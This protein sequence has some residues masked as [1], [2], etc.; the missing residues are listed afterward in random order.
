MTDTISRAPRGALALAALAAE[1]RR[2]QAPPDR[3]GARAPSD[4]PDCAPAGPPPAAAS[5]SASPAPSTG[6]AGDPFGGQLAREEVRGGRS[7]YAA[8]LRA[9]RG[10]M[11]F[12]MLLSAGVAVLMLTGPIYMV[13][14]YDRVLA[15]GS[16]ST[17]TALFALAM[18]LYGFLGLY[19]YIRGR[20]LTRAAYRLDA[21]LAEPAFRA[22]LRAASG[23]GDAREDA[24]RRRR[25]GSAPPAPSDPVADVETVRGFVSGPAMAG[26][27]DLPFVPLFLGVTFLVHPAVGLVTLAGM[28]LAGI[29]ALVNRRATRRVLAEGAGMQAATA[30]FSEAL[31]GDAAGLR[32]M[33]MEDHVVRRRMEMHAAAAATLQQGGERGEGYA[34]ASRTLRMMLQSILLT[35]GAVLAI[36]GEISAGMIIAISIVAGRALAPL[37]QAI[38]QWPMIE[39]A[40][41]AHRGLLGADLRRPAPA[42]T[43][44]PEMTGHLTLTGVTVEARARGRA[45]V[46]DG[47]ALDL[48]PGDA[49]GVIGHSASGKST[50]ARVL[51]GALIP[52][53][54]EA[55]IDGAEHAQWDP[56]V[57]SR[58]LGYLPQ[59]VDL[60][61]GTIAENIARF[62]PAR[63]DAEIVAA[64]RLAGVHEMILA[65]P[66]GYRTRIDGAAP[67]SGGQVQRVGLARAVIGLPRLVVLD[68][69]N[70]HLDAPGDAALTRVVRA[71]RASGAAVVV[72]THRPAGLEAVN[73][74]LV[75]EGG[76]VAREGPKSMLMGAVGSGPGE[77]GQ[78]EEAPAAGPRRRGVRDIAAASR[79]ARA[80]LQTSGA[81]PAARAAVSAVPDRPDE[82]ALRAPD[83]LAAATA[84][85]AAGTLRLAPEVVAPARSGAAREGRAARPGDRRGGGV[86]SARAAAPGRRLAVR[87]LVLAAVLPSVGLA[88]LVGGW[89]A[90]APIDGAVVAS[91]AIDLRGQAKSVQS[92]D[93]GTVAEILVREGQV[94]AG[95]APLL[96]LDTTQ[97]EVEA[98]ILRGRLSEAALRERR[99]EAERVGAGTLAF[100]PLPPE[101]AGR[102]LAVEAAGQRAI[103]EARAAVRR[104][105]DEQLAER[106]A[107]VDAQIEGA[108]GQIAAVERQIALAAEEEDRARRLSEQ[109]LARAER[110]RAA[111]DRTADLG[112]RLAAL[113]SE[114]AR[115]AIALQDARL[116]LVQA[117]RTF[118]EGVVTELR[119]A[120]AETGELRLRLAEIGTRIARAEIP[121]PVSGMVHEMTVATVGGT[122]APGEVLMEVV[123]TGGRMDVAVKID[124]AQIDEIR[125]GQPVRVM[126]SG[127]GA[128][129]AP[130]IEGRV[131][132]ISP[133]AVEDRA[134]GR[135]FYRVGI[136]LPEA[137]VA[138]LEASG[139]GPLVPGMPV[140][141]FLT[142]GARTVLSYLARPI[143]DQFRRAFR[144]S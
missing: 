9:G 72:M 134:D 106:A 139:S 93:G 28:V 19:S 35:V 140:E 97:L 4:V 47:V 75:L 36:R 52:D 34:S 133:R 65:L 32:A 102:D 138:A 115:A 10:T 15:S 66:S 77:A 124:P 64:A 43:A 141:A 70:A 7:L 16:M 136:E 83:A 12:A 116:A 21:A 99:L 62:D 24:A 85:A 135:A 13:Q 6:A 1:P 37:D 117:E 107:Q 17:L 119:D 67:L 128:A 2:R 88:A 81:A 51:V 86:L 33:G 92:L 144:E 14:V 58:A 118:R 20:V 55:R 60:L 25:D 100:A 123:P 90:L 78:G 26:L 96:R 73:R 63:T 101:I 143:A 104:G 127:L 122:I 61:P 113:R 114:A 98:D 137:E 59:R 121:A 103:F 87:P 82:G 18:V 11:A 109:G 105:E 142:T 31:R 45:P 89:M 39:R 54:G 29:V 94:V 79:A 69:P 74:L 22:A 111:Q 53:R 125:I 91:G 48:A 120:A 49:L 84:E 3:A 40:L 57:L 110:L 46:L 42:P 38:G 5:A 30:R 130:E 50:L 8:A 56:A 126:L 27:M 44:L 80:R 129:D 108:R 95:G 23:R 71:L 41:R 112:G 76:R 131:M 132:R 68:E